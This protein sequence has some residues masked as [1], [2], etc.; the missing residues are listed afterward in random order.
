M[1]KRCIQAGILL[2]AV[3]CGTPP[4]ASA[5]SFCLTMYYNCQRQCGL[6]SEFYCEPGPP[7]IVI[8]ECLR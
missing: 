7:A 1:V 4:K 3:L 2:A 8:C 6:I 5:A